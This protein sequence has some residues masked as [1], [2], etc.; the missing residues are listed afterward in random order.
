M[1]TSFE[2]Y[3]D[4]LLAAYQTSGKANDLAAKKKEIFSDLF[5]Q[6]DIDS[7]SILFVGFNPGILRVQ[8]FDLAVTEGSS[9]V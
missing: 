6:F 7:G 9:E 3:N 8:N 2:K 4:I 1:S 5:N